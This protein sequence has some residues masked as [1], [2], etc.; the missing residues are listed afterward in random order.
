MVLYAIITVYFYYNT[1]G[2]V[3][4]RDVHVCVRVRVRV[5]VRV[6]V[7]AMN[8]IKKMKQAYANVVLQHT[9]HPSACKSK[10]TGI[11]LPAE[12]HSSITTKRMFGLVAAA[13]APTL[14][15]QNKREL[16]IFK[17]YST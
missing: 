17:F 4:L 1:E 14:Q 16:D 12:T 2:L 11:N 13:A 15:L 10:Q 5:R 7:S 6:P 3:A 8:Y 9:F